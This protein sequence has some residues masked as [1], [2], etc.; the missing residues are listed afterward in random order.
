MIAKAEQLTRRESDVDSDVMRP[1]FVH[2]A[3]EEWRPVEPASMVFSMEVLYYY[4]EPVQLLTTFRS[5]LADD[6]V[7]ASGV[8][9]F[10]EHAASHAWP[11]ATGLPM[12]L[13]GE[14]EWAAALVEA[15]F[16][17]VSTARV[18]DTLSLYGRR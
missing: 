17:D 13:L 6:G 16:V 5:W 10:G 2:T 3:L 9:Y 12:T 7:F 14:A 18:G 4:Q 15:G 8:D 11:E 1:T